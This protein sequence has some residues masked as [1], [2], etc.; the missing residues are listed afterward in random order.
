MSVASSKAGFLLQRVGAL[1]DLDKIIYLG[2]VILA[3]TRQPSPSRGATKK[4][5][6][7]IQYFIAT[8]LLTPRPVN[9]AAYY[10]NALALGAEALVLG[11]D[12]GLFNRPGG[13][14]AHDHGA[15]LRHAYATAHLAEE[16][17]RVAAL[18]A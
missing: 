14:W 11:D 6:W 4:I 7:R 2:M 9:Y 12:T 1:A 13:G 8:G 16:V 10:S 17:P 5:P 18:V 3:A 15:Q